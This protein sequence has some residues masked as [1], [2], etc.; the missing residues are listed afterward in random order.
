M[1]ATFDCMKP[2]RVPWTK[3]RHCGNEVAIACSF[4]SVNWGFAGGYV[5][6]CPNAS[7]SLQAREIV[8]SA[9]QLKGF[10]ES[11]SSDFTGE[12]LNILFQFVTLSYCAHRNCSIK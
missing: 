8:E 6:Y 10:P 3:S 4:T 12:V 11:N 2:R 5:R 7:T 1:E 9:L